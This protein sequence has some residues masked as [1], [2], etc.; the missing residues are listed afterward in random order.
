MIR[1]TRNRCALAAWV[2]AFLATS[3]AQALAHPNVVLIMADDLAYNDL[4]CYGSQRIK[5]PVLDKMAEEGIRLTSFYAGATVC[6][7]SRMALLSGSYPTRIGWECGVIGH[8]MK[9]FSGLPRDV[10][11]IAEAFQAA[12]YRTALSGKWHIGKL[13][14]APMHQ[15]FDETYYLLASNNQTKKLWRGMEVV[16]ES[17]ENRRFSETFT[18]EAIRFITTNKENS[19]F[20]YLPY[21]APHFPAESHPDWDGHSA[22]GAYGDVVE[23]LDSRIGEILTALKRH[24]LDGDTIVVFLS[25]NGTERIQLEFSSTE[26]YTGG[27]WS[28][29]EGGTR[30]PCIV[31]WPGVIPA[32]QVSDELAAAVDLFPTLAHACGIEIEIPETGQ[33]LDGINVWD[34]LLGKKTSHPRPDLLYWHGWGEAR[35][36]RQGDWK[37]F[38]GQ[39]E[40]VPSSNEGPALFNLKE[41]PRESQNLSAQHPDIVDTMMALARRRLEDIHQNHVPIGAED[42]A[43]GRVK[44]WTPKKKWGKWLE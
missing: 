15:G 36:I 7:P 22:N 20:L 12:G 19:F 29:R 43:R 21:T 4:S 37:L 25:D 26:P 18:Q 10:V 41:D 24:E 27:K 33:K 39:E 8:G 2:F 32:G 31:R 16:D 28:A 34:T 5:T 30:V 23:E 6:S 14:L 40:G 11:T 1:F 17:F 35:A 38:F 44:D 13:E 9:G 42:N 3:N